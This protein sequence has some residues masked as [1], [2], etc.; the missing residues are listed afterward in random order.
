MINNPKFTMAAKNI[1]LQ[2][3]L[4][5]LASLAL[6]YRRERGPHR[7]RELRKDYTTKQSRVTY[8]TPL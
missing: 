6:R 8:V 3:A 1:L 7:E 5:D 4:T 2:S